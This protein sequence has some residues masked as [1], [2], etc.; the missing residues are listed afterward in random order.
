M[1]PQP[2]IVGKHP[3]ILPGWEWSADKAENC[4]HCILV[5]IDWDNH[6]ADDFD[7]LVKCRANYRGDDCH[8]PS[9]LNEANATQ[10]IGKS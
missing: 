1:A 7:S 2:L 8:N 9:P 5:D 3:P 4:I 10:V 6:W